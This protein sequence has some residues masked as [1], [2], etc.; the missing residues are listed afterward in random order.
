VQADRD[1]QSKH[2]EVDSKG[3]DPKSKGVRV[4]QQD[5]APGSKGAKPV[6]K[7]ERLVVQHARTVAKCARVLVLDGSDEEKIVAVDFDEART[8]QSTRES[9]KKARWCSRRAGGI[10]RSAPP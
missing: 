8:R 5:G 4:A 1:R 6:A 9:S 7:D 10:E 2:D 3:V